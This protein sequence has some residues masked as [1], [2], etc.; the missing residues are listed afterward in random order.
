M[1]TYAVG[2]G[3]SYLSSKIIDRYLVHEE[4]QQSLTCQHDEGFGFFYCYRSDPSRRN[5]ESI[6]RS[7]IRQLS[8]VP[9][10]SENI[11]QASLDLY[12]SGKKVQHGLNLA[13]CMDTLARFINSYP[14]VT[15]VL[16]TLDECDDDTK[17]ELIKL[18]Q[19]LVETSKGMLKIFIASRKEVDI[20][21][22]L[23]S[24][25]VRRSLTHL[26]TSDN[27]GDI[28]R[29][30]SHEINESGPPWKSITE[31]TKLLAKDTLVKKSDGM[32]VIIGTYPSTD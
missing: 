22:Y 19:N 14:R 28:E 15:L 21:N 16:D 30:I 1:M 5:T 29:F 10:R 24:F 7:Y 17:R 8:E 9:R 20:E 13:Q 32:Q 26:T 18:F 23:E 12:N 27:T 25:H 6:L 2:T 3:K 31:E 11:H 4:D